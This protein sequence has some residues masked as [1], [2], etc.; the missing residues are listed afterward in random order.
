MCKISIIVPAFNA[1]KTIDRCITSIQKQSVSDI[2]IIIVNDGSTDK[3]KDI[4]MSYAESDDRIYLYNTANNGPSIAREYGVQRAKGEYIVFV[5]SDDNLDKEFC[6]C[7]LNAI[8]DC[9]IVIGGRIVLSDGYE[10]KRVIPEYNA[11]VTK[12]EH[13]G[14]VLTQKLNSHILLSRMFRTSFIRENNLHFRN[15][16]LY[17][18]LEFCF[19]ASVSVK[20]VKYIREAIYY[21]NITEASASSRMS[22]NQITDFTRVICQ[23]Y[24][25]LSETKLFNNVQDKFNYFLRKALYRISTLYVE[26]SVV[27]EK[28]YKSECRKVIDIIRDCRSFK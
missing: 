25:V 20:K 11:V 4:V 21:Y 27:D 18:D 24:H 14:M 28:I 16:T 15:L 26:N 10:V 8:D 12:N 1:E 22:S 13:M 2:E 9:D 23:I 5:D 17:E 7:M 19:S 3:T 6:Y